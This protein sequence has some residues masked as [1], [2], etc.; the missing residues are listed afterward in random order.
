M[1]SPTARAENRSFGPLSAL[2]ALRALRAH[3]KNA[4]QNWFTMENA[5]GL[6]RPGTAR[7]DAHEKLLLPRDNRIV[8]Q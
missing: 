1:I 8:E 7:T 6:N 4:I 2:R 3:T 5:K